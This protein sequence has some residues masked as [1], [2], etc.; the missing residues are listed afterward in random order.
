MKALISLL[1]LAS[2]CF[3]TTLELV[4]TEEQLQ[5]ALEDAVEDTRISV[6][7]VDIQEGVIVLTASRMVLQQPVELD[8]EIWLDPSADENIWCVKSATANGNPLSENRIEL[9]NQWLN[10]G[11]RNMA[12]TELGR[13]DIIS[14]EPEQ[15]TFIWN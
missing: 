7:D 9:W 15:I 2:V 5:A 11:M 1:V 3:S 12:Q 13:A 10:T 4:I 8:I 6:L 14:I